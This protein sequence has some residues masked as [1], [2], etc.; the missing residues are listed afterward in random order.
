MTPPNKKQKEKKKDL[1]GIDLQL[2]EGCR[3]RA[4][5]GKVGRRARVSELG[6]GAEPD[7]R[8]SPCPD[9]Q[10]KMQTGEGGSGQ[11]VSCEDCRARV[12]SGWARNCEES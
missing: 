3:A 4:Q 2:L 12:L 9:T 10:Q 5:K 6:P 8:F 11:K 1:Q 7:G